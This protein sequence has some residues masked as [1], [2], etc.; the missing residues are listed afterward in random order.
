MRLRNKPWAAALIKAHPELIQVTPDQVADQF[1]KRQPVR[2]EIGTGKGQFIFRMAQQNPSINFVALEMQH[3]ALA[4]LLKQ[5]VE[6][7]LPNLQLVVANAN[8]LATAFAGWHF[9]EIY[10]NFSDPWPKTRHEKRRL[11]YRSFLTQYRQLLV[12]DGV[13]QLKTDNRHFFEYSLMSM[14]QYGMRFRQLSLDL[15]HDDTPWAQKNVTTEYEDKFAAKGQ[16]IYAVRA[17]FLPAHAK[18]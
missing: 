15:H 1:E 7:K 12:P 14:N 11:T 10:L 16:P 2:L 18:G 13:V 5:Q 3:S 4:V 8:T 6:A 17:V 9:T